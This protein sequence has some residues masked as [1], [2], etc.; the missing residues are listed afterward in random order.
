MLVAYF[1]R[2]N[3]FLLSLVLFSFCCLM[4]FASAAELSAKHTSDELDEVIANVCNKKIILLG[5]DSSH[6]SGKTIE[7][8]ISIVKRLINECGFSAVFFESP[9]YEFIYF[10]RSLLGRTSTPQQ[11]A[12]SIG[13]LWSTAK[14]M[15]PFISDLYLKALDGKIRLFGIDAQLGAAGQTF[16]QNKLA[17]QLAGYLIEQRKGVCENSLHRYLNWQ[18]DDK[19]PY[20]DTTKKQIASCISEIK[21]EIFK[22]NRQSN[23]LAVDKFMIQNFDRFLGF[24]SGNYFNLRDKSMADNVAW[25]LSKLAPEEKIIVWSASVH[26]A[27]SL[28]PFSTSHIPMGYYIHQSFPNQVAS[29]GFSALTGSYGRSSATIKTIKK[30]MLEEKILLGTSEDL[31][32]V[33]KKSLRKL[34]KISAQPIHYNNIKLANWD[35]VLDG[36]I[37]LRQE[38]PLE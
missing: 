15:R 36:I 24:E 6:G 26:S 9:V 16:T 19:S 32:Y 37:V 29:I 30:S 38:S 28:A 17:K 20:N 7:V 12:Q 33:D 14:S 10:Q 25:N 5:E 23:S 1:Q 2:E 22:V 31:K 8:K 18:Y 35:E 34:G 4:S 27:K 21:D 11:L 13:G 3:V